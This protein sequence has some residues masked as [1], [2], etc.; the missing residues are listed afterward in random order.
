ML[1]FVKY[2]L[3]PISMKKTPFVASLLKEEKINV[4]NQ[5]MAFGYYNLIISIRDLKLYCH[6]VKPHRRW[7]ISD[8]KKYFGVSGSKEKVLEQLQELQRI[9]VTPY[10][11]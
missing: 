3:K 1:I 5:P 11:N 6:G 9:Y 7:K 10:K 4:N 8:V 2:S